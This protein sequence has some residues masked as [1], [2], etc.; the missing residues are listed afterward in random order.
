M[1]GVFLSSFLDRPTWGLRLYLIAPMLAA[2]WVAGKNSPQLKNFL[3]YKNRSVIVQLLNF[4][5]K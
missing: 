2:K 3:V 4:Q 1:R 5:G